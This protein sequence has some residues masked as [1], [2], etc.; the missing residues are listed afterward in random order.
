MDCVSLTISR[1]RWAVAGASP[2]VDI[3]SFHHC[4]RC[5]LVDPA[6]GQTARLPLSRITSANQP[7]QGPQDQSQPPL[8]R[9]QGHTTAPHIRARFPI[10]EDDLEP[11]RLGQQAPRF[12]QEA[13]LAH[14]ALCGQQGRS[15]VPY[16]LFRC[17]S[18]PSSGR[19]NPLRQPGFSRPF[20]SR[21]CPNDSVGNTLV[22]KPG[23]APAAFL[24]PGQ[25]TT[26]SPGL[27]G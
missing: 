24:Y 21:H 10:D 9:N 2:V 6:V 5:R 25:P 26:V 23:F 3:E 17:F 1:K 19:R 7:E 14:T 16:R 22:A 13:R 20:A 18:A 11:A 12:P 8:P 27:P 15:S 4:C